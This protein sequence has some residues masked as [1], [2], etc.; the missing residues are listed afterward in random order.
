MREVCVTPHYVVF[1]CKYAC[2]HVCECLNI[3]SYI[4]AR[5]YIIVFIGVHVCARSSHDDSVVA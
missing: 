2:L 5:R 1:A 4:N 3:Y